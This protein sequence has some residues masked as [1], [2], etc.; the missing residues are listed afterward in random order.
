MAI[1]GKDSPRAKVFT[2]FHELCHI[3]IGASGFCDLHETADRTDGIEPFCNRVA[4][5]ALVPSRNL[6]AEPLVTQH[7][8]V[9]WEEWRVRELATT[10]GVSTEVLLRRLVTFGHTTEAFYHA[11]RDEYLRAYADTA[12]ERSGFLAHFR[13][14]LIE[15]CISN[16]HR[17]MVATEAWLPG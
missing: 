16:Q 6:L 8:S 14:V 10:Y 3:A 4:T 9:E 12:A 2:L 17:I 11:K 7:H 5:E 15:S 1:D 13:Q